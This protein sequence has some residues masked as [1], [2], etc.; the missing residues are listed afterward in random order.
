MTDALRHAKQ[1]MLMARPWEAAE[2][3]SI[4]EITGDYPGGRGTFTACLAMVVPH[5]VTGT[6]QPLFVMISP[7]L[8]RDE[9]ISPAQI[10]HAVPL[11]L[12]HRDDPST[13]YWAADREWMPQVSR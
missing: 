13:P 3:N 1:Q 4:W 6:D 12:V 7:A 8:Q 10:T 2:E 11:L 5:F 9:P